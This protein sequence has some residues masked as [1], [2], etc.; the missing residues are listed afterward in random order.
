MIYSVRPAL[1]MQP[2]RQRTFDSCWDWFLRLPEDLVVIS[3]F[4]N[5]GGVGTWT[6]PAFAFQRR[7]KSRFIYIGRPR[8]PVVPIRLRFRLTCHEI[9]TW[10]RGTGQLKV[11]LDQTKTVCSVPLFG[12]GFAGRYLNLEDLTKSA[13]RSEGSVPRITKK[14]VNFMCLH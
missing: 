6:R 3:L 12:R 13:A 14:I 8:V 11:L 4:S 1:K 7:R 2:Q 5:I 9:C 10:S